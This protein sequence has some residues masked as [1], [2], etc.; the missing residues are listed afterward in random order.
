MHSSSRKLVAFAVLSSVF[1]TAMSPTTRHTTRRID[2]NRVETFDEVGP[3]R[4]LSVSSRLAISSRKLAKRN[5]DAK[6]L[7]CSAYYVLDSRL[8]RL[9]VVT[10]SKSWNDEWKLELRNET[11]PIRSRAE[12]AGSLVDLKTN[13]KIS[14]GITSQ[15]EKSITFQIGSSADEIQKFQKD[16]KLYIEVKS[17][18]FN[19]KM[20]LP[21]TKAVIDRINSCHNE[22]K[23]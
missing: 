22:K 5:Q 19:N 9:F 16:D 13:E 8:G 20:E 3:W 7:A 1:L 6:H 4:V 10:F 21:N 17:S 14:N 2:T 11:W 18:A 12:I 15:K 23:R